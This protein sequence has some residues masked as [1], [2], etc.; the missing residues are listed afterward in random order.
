MLFKTIVDRTQT[1]LAYHVAYTK[2]SELTTGAKEL[3]VWR[4][5]KV[6]HK[7]RL[8][9]FIS[10]DKT[11]LLVLNKAYNSSAYGTLQEFKI[12]WER[13]SVP[14]QL[15]WERKSE[16]YMIDVDLRV[17]KPHG[18]IALFSF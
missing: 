18:R 10:E 11:K 2:W 3:I 8:E 15:E 6:F 12:H 4:K 13:N 7:A 16:N 17:T 9:S 1:Q 5:K 14:T